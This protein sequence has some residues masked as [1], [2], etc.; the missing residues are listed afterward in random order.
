MDSSRVQAPPLRAAWGRGG[1]WPHPVFD[2]RLSIFVPVAIIPAVANPDG[3]ALADSRGGPYRPGADDTGAPVLP[4]LRRLSQRRVH[5]P[6]PLL[7]PRSPAALRRRG[8]SPL[9]DR[10]RRRR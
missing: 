9:G 10:V 8:G 7:R 3:R 1:T 2:F 4:S 5:G 6:L